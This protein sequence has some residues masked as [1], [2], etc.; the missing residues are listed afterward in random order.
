M[1]TTQDFS[2]QEFDR[3]MKQLVKSQD[4]Q[5]LSTHFT[6]NLMSR[7]EEEKSAFTYKPIISKQAMI[8]IAVLFGILLLL[9]QFQSG[10]TTTGL[11]SWPEFLTIPIAGL[12]SNWQFAFHSFSIQSLISSVLFLAISG[13]IL[14]LGVHYVFMVVLA[15]RS[16]KKVNEM[17]AF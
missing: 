1:N 16:K 12:L 10:H 9:T 17:Y 3:E 7:I 15:N 2:E 14:A 4:G 8:L 5:K 11:W 6:T 13:L